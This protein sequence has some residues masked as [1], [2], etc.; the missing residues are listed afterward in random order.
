MCDYDYDED[1]GV[2]D[3]HHVVARKEHRC[4]ACAETIAPGHEYVRTGSLSDGQW[5]TYRHC[6]R[7]WAMCE[8]LWAR[9]EGPIDVGLCCGE[10]WEAPPDAIAALAFLTHEEAQENFA[11]RHGG[12]G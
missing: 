10:T 12:A 2:W 7:C 1:G 3:P 9:V 4:Y 6:L 8:A 5:E 11:K